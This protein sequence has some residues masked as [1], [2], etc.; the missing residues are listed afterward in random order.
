MKDI[1]VSGS[2]F[3]KTKD[4]D[5]ETLII[6]SDEGRSAIIMLPSLGCHADFCF[7]ESISG[8]SREHTLYLINHPNNGFSAGSLRVEPLIDSISEVAR[9]LGERHDFVFGLGH[10]FGSFVLSGL[11]REYIDGLV[12]IGM[13]LNLGDTKI[14]NTFG[15][16]GD[17]PY[18]VARIIFQ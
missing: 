16:I 17:L 15:W 13:P 12:L 7:D 4:H 3:F 14:A 10:S 9:K 5:L 8:L 6:G 18:P 2:M 1:Q 11:S